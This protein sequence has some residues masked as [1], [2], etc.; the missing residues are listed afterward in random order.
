MKSAL[1]IARREAYAYLRS[2]LGAAVIAAVLLGE[3]LYFYWAGLTQRQVSAEVL[4]QFFNVASGGILLATPVLSMRLVA[5]ERQ[6]GTMTLLNTAPV[7]DRDIVL[8]KFISAFAMIALMTALSFYM[9]A[10]IFVNGKV[11][12]GHIAVGYLGVLLLGAAVTSIGLFASS[13]SRSQVLAVIVT[14]VILVTLLLMWMVARAVDPPFNEFAAA[15]ALH[16]D[17][18]RPFMQGTLKLGSVAYYLAISFFFLL[19][20]I[21]VLE[22]RRWH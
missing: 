19:S 15:L 11:S 2:P 17:N 5:E 14:A 7:R 22:A 10:L 1:L 6:T 12:L 13:V 18:Y 16:H 9:P 20:A 4:Q 21:K 3:G 8:G